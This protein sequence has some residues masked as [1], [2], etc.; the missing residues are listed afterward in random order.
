MREY[1]PG[2]KLYYFNDKLD[3]WVSELILEDS[4]LAIDAKNTI[5]RGHASVYKD[6]N[7]KRQEDYSVEALD[8]METD[9]NIVLI[10]FYEFHKRNHDSVI[11]EYE[12]KIS[13]A[14]MSLEDMEDFVDLPELKIKYAEYFV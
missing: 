5:W 4:G 12:L 8:S 10:K 14:E 3:N 6:N 9:V 11:R 1:S 7:S 13:Q 2:M